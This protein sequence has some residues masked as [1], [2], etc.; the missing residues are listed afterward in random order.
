MLPAMASCLVLHAP[1]DCDLRA[2]MLEA[3][4]RRKMEAPCPTALDVTNDSVTICMDRGL[5][6]QKYRGDVDA[7]FR[8]EVRP[9]LWETSRR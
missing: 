9:L 7:A 6:N 3:T 5:L 8:C 1:L 2:E 4:K